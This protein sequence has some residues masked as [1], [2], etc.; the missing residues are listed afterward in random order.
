MTSS[1]DSIFA[2]SSA[3]ARSAI[4]IHRIS[5]IN[6]LK[7]FQGYL[8]KVKSNELINTSL[9][10]D[11]IKSKPFTQYLILKDTEGNIIDDV[12]FSYFK[13]PHSYTGEDV[14]EISS[15]GN[16]LISSLLQRL[17]RHLGLRDALPGEFTQRAYLNSKIDLIQAEGI[18]QLI[19]TET[20]G[21]IQLARESVGGELSKETEEVKNILIEIM[22]YLEAHID[23]APD[24]VG[25]YQPESLLP[26]MKQALN[27][28][29]ILLKSY[30]SGLRAREGV[31]IALVGKPNAGKSSLYNALLKYERAIV[32]HIPGTTRDVLEDRLIIRNKD[33]VLMDTAG[34]RETEDAVEKIG[35][36]RSIKTLTKA[37][38]ICLVITLENVKYEDYHKFIDESLSEFLLSSEFFSEQ[39][40]LPVFSKMDTIPNN[41]LEIIENSYSIIIKDKK[42]HN[43]QSILSKK[44]IFCSYLDT[45]ILSS[46]LVELH[47]Q[48]TG[49]LG[50]K[51]NPTLISERQRNK[52]EIAVKNLNEG[53]DLI[54]KKDYPEKISSVINQGRQSLQEVVGEIQL[55]DVLE[56]IFS[57]FCIGK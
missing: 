21:G 12:L 43:F 15:H 33:F 36:E 55:D 52:I 56:K 31:K 6:L 23:F 35:V 22:A 14:I 8:F 51:N 1:I 3:N 40:I 46:E 28:M 29:Q 42:F 48:L 9:I 20:L 5:G 17:F 54:Y 24:E 18:N 26:L 45:E 7:Y 50:Q 44:C 10:N 37:D 41:S 19:H 47:D 57:T 39:I 34:I 16:P 13:A 49:L 25:D 27:K 32:T 11:Q 38:I 53:I 30:S 4:H 2:L